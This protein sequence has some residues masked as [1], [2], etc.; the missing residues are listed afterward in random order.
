MEGKEAILKRSHDAQ[1]ITATGYGPAWPPL[2]P[3]QGL[4][5]GIAHARR[6]GPALCLFITTSSDSLGLLVIS[7]RGLGINLDT[8]SRHWL[9]LISVCILFL[10][11]L[12]VFLF[13]IL[14]FFVNVGRGIAID[15]FLGRGNGLLLLCRR[16]IAYVYSRGVL[17][18]S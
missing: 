1:G 10:F 5:H 3:L 13:L 14:F 7:C 16:L 2:S 11:F 12:Y 15:L 4:H 9:V 18:H 8:F 6:F 17:A